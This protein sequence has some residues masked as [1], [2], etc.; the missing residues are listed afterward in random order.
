MK[1]FRD[2][3]LR[4]P[5]APACVAT[6]GNFDG[7]HLGHQALIDRVEKEAAARELAAVLVTFE[8]LAREYFAPEKAPGRIYNASQRIRQLSRQHLD[9]VWLMRFNRYLASLS[10]DEFVQYLIKGINPQLVVVGEGFRFGRDRAG[11]VE[12]LSFGGAVEVIAMPAVCVDN[13]R[14]SSTRIRRV[15][16]DGD[17]DAAARLLGR[18]FGMYGRVVRGQQLGRTLG[19]PTANI[20]LHRRSTPINGIFAV[21]VSGG[22]LTQQPGVASIG[23]RPTVGGKETLLE[24]HVFDFSGDLYGAHLDV[25]LV[26]KLRDEEKFDDLDTMT[27]Q[28]HEDARQARKLLAA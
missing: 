27:V 11:T 9:A 2:L 12:S 7:I 15:L 6:I 28:M 23:T 18:P 22:G 19:F 3:D 26:A 4:Q 13:E 17:M 8:P 5:I 10:A 14:V 24:V 25:T 16:A 20:R 21:R 1:L